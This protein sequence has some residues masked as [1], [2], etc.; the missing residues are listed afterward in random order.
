MNF[1][2][3]FYTD[4]ETL[5]VIIAYMC[6]VYLQIE[7]R[8][9]TTFLIIFAEND[10]G[11]MEIFMANRKKYGIIAGIV[12]IILVIFGIINFFFNSPKDS[13]AYAV[14]MLQESIY[15]HDQV[16]FNSIVNVDRLLSTSFDS[17][18]EGTIVSD[19]SMPEEVK[20]HIVKF[21]QML[22]V[23]MTESLKTAIKNYVEYGSFEDRGQDEK[24]Q[25][26]QDSNLIA[27]SEILDR[28]GL[29]RTTFREI[30]SV[31]M[32]KDNDK[33]AVAFIKVYQQE[34][35]REF[36]FEVL[37]EKSNQ[38]VWR[39]VSIRN[40]K[41]FVELV[42]KAR[43]D[44]LDTYLSETEP[45]ISRHDETIRDAEQKYSKILSS[46]SLGKDETREKLRALM[47]DVVKKDWEERKQELFDI[48]VPQGAESLQNLRI[49]ICDLSIES[50]DLYAKWMNDKKAA[51][52]KEA[53][54]KR[55]QVQVLLSEEKILVSR[56][57][58]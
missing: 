20:D 27:A 51:T 22:K 41:N 58:K 54:D 52:V 2:R 5:P 49:K 38:D 3:K 29:S 10:H 43:R 39:V 18:V 17:F 44:Q 21:T 35:G 12:A 40:F 23:P 57:S 45:I 56:M 25:S 46:G 7:E 11:R 33:Q 1:C 19:E 34:I 32:I 24:S 6:S 16:T 13:P 42:N 53:E 50:A 9:Y 55:K 36:T 47:I 31:K 28:T 8:S 37:L 26:A 30:D 4:I 48:H 14:K 15:N